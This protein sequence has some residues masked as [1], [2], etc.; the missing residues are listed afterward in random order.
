MYRNRNLDQLIGLTI[1]AAALLWALAG[2]V[3]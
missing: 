1:V 2:V 3:A